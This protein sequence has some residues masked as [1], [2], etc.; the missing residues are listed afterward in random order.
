MIRIHKKKNPNLQGEEFIDWTFVALLENA[1]LDTDLN[2]INRY[3]SQAL[4]YKNIGREW[5]EDCSDK[6]KQDYIYYKNCKCEWC[7]DCKTNYCT[8]ELNTITKA[9]NYAIDLAIK[10]LDD[11]QLVDLVSS[12]VSHS[13]KITSNTLL[14][15]KS[16]DVLRK[17]FVNKL[18]NHKRNKR[19]LTW[20]N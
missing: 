14:D 9:K 10:Y 3:I 6:Q 18:K 2:K 11:N 20:F 1:L 5:C 8:C 4:T 19:I 13:P 17:N 16:F 15:E 12:I 7:E